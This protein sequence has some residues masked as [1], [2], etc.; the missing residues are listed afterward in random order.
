M[1]P[2]SL[3]YTIL[4]SL[5]LFPFIPKDEILYNNALSKIF[6]IL[7]LLSGIVFYIFSL[8]LFKLNKELQKHL[9]NISKD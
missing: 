5:N 6:W 9:A 2:I 3:M 4:Q 7:S 8:K 1:Y